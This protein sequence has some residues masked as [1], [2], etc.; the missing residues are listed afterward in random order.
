MEFFN[1]LRYVGRVHYIQ[2]VSILVLMEFFNQLVKEDVIYRVVK[3]V[4]ILVLM[5]FF[6]QPSSGI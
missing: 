1:Q 2:S 5:E 6:N 4:S 3:N